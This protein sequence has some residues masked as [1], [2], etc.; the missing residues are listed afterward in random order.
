MY[1]RLNPECYYVKGKSHGAIY[2]LIEGDVYALDSQESQMIEDC[3]NNRMVDHAE[4]FL[5]D[6]KK[7]VIGNFYEK[8]VFIEK[9]RLGSP[10]AEYQ[11]GIPPVLTRAFLEISNNCNQ[12]CWYCGFQGISRSM[13]CLGCNKWD[14]DGTAVSMDRWKELIDE[15]HILRCQL[16]FI[17]GG[18]L[19][20]EWEKTC[21]ILEYANNFFEKIFVTFHRAHL[22]KEARNY[23]KNK[24][25][26]II[27][28][29]NLSD[30][31]N[32]NVYLLAIDLEKAN[33][34]L[35]NP[36]K[37]VIVDT[38][39]Q[40]FAP[41]QPRSVTLS[42][43]NI[44]KTNLERFTHNNKLHPCLGNSVTISWNGEVLPCPMMRKQSLGNINDKKLW[45]FFK[46]TPGSIQDYWNISLNKLKK[47]SNCEF[48][49]A[50]TDCRAL[51]VAQTG[52]LYSK[53]LCN[54]DPSQGTWQQL[55]D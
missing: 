52:D 12:S 26:L 44:D 18:D 20:N 2:D 28:T 7:R 54:Y 40:N 32:Q 14:E 47:C 55:D 45:T 41:L 53:I 5:L 19:T 24:A 34:L 21:E 3:E 46:G 48:R 11:E 27:Q 43:K 23:L 9:L 13:G 33:Y 51:E 35:D 37:N 6:L 10:I 38:I 16:L 4:P 49:Y 30:I 22:S 15:L 50:C 36:H 31:D 1:F 8:K 17:K 29:D 25:N 39:S 42:K